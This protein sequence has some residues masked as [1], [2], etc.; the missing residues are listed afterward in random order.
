[1]RAAIAGTPIGA[2]MVNRIARG[3]LGLSL[4]L[5]LLV[6]PSQVT[7]QAG[8]EGLGL[9]ADRVAWGSAP[10]VSDS[11]LSGG[12]VSDRPMV[13]TRLVPLS[14]KYP[15]IPFL[16]PEEDPAA[17]DA[18]N[19]D[20]WGAKRN[21]G[22]AF[23]E[24]F[25]TNVV[26]WL[27]N[28]FV[29]EA[30]FSQVNPKSWLHNIETG[31]QWDDNHFSTNHFAH[32]YQ[33]SLYFNAFRSNG[34]SFWESYP[35]AFV[36]SFLWE[37]CGETHLMSANDLV[38]TGMG[39]VTLGEMLYRTSSMVLDNEA[40]GTSRVW[41]ELAGFAINPV[42]GATRLFTGRAGEVR[43]NPT[44]EWDRKPPF[45]TTR[46]N[47][48]YRGQSNDLDVDSIA[49]GGFLERQYVHGSPLELTRS[50]PFDYFILQLDLNTG[51][52]SLLGRLQVSGNLWHTDA[53]VT[54]RS[55]HRFFFF[56]NFDY[57]ENRAYEFGGQ[58]ISAAVQSMWE[59]GEVGGWTLGS[60]FDAYFM[61]MGAV[62]S[63]FAFIAEVP[64]VRENYRTYDF[65][66]GIGGRAVFTVDR[67]GVR[68]FQARYRATFLHTLN[69]SVTNGS[70]ANHLIHMTQVMARVPIRGAWSFGADLTGFFR[71]SYY[72]LEELED[73]TQRAPQ[74]RLYVTW[75]GG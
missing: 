38:N 3:S 59:V 34:Y 72:S 42:R 22:L 31:F 55:Q 17:Q 14:E 49:S 58:S 57:F 65:G 6:V 64:G 18:E 19:R 63:D 67:N 1:M 7:A 8:P 60:S 48:G 51:D 11:L 43:P 62:N 40:T 20:A 53:R 35:W 73:T 39:G 24:L 45:Q 4:V 47:I 33:G 9:S 71:D 21:F 46:M 70:D 54:E 37:C 25:L 74:G 12:V 10:S 52:R 23:S 13:P 5:A 36:G 29:R 16:D 66:V 30:D 50:K 26:P 61:P 32:P 56:Q 69:G 2:E 27:F 28:E 15:G 75:T 41:K 68:V 44:N